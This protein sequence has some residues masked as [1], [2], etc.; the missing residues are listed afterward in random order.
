[1]NPFPL[2]I[3][4]ELSS[5]EF[6][7]WSYGSDSESCQINCVQFVAAVLEKLLGEKLDSEVV[8][9][10]FVNSIKP[11]SLIHNGPDSRIAFK[12][13]Q[14]AMVNMLECAVQIEP[15][16][17]E[18]GDFIQYYMKRKDGT[19]FGHASI[20]DSIEAETGNKLAYLFGAHASTKGIAVS[21]FRLNLT[22]PN[23]VI[24]LARY[25]G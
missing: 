22:G 1:M 20:I 18:S 16:E 24:Y 3:A 19:W 6:Y 2:M 15:E 5:T 12:G 8:D 23:R 4:K 10:I 11:E 14:H 25:S 13:I 17:A 9:Q 7:G 21:E